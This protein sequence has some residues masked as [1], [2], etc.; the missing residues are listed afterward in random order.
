MT[1]LPPVMGLTSSNC[2]VKT[3]A[4]FVKHTQ[5]SHCYQEGML[6]ASPALP[7]TGP[8]AVRD[9]R[10]FQIK[11]SISFLRARLGSCNKTFQVWS[12]AP[13]AAALMASNKLH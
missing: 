12:Q 3:Y 7:D 2:I 13:V 11:R 4:G 10:K 5:D 9:A 6:H 8:L 1:V